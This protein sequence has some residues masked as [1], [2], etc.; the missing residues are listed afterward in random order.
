MKKLISALLVVFQIFGLLGVFAETDKS[1]VFLWEDFN[2]KKTGEVITDYLGSCSV[3]ADGR[4][5]Y[6][7]TTIEDATK[8]IELA[9]SFPEK[10][11]V[12]YDFYSDATLSDTVFFKIKDSLSYEYELYSVSDG[13][14]NYDKQYVKTYNK[15]KWNNI[16]LMF[17]SVRKEFSVMLNGEYVV[18]RYKLPNMR[19]YSVSAVKAL[20]KA[21]SGE[22]GTLRVDNIYAYSGDTVQKNLPKSIF[23]DEEVEKQ[24]EQDNT[25]N[26]S[27]WDYS[28]PQFWVRE[29]FEN[30]DDIYTLG[31]NIWPKGNPNWGIRTDD[32]GNKYLYMDRQIDDPFVDIVRNLE[33]EYVAGSYPDDEYLVLE[34]DFTINNLGRTILFD[35]KSRTAVSAMLVEMSN[36]GVLTDFN[37]VP[38]DSV[39]KGDKFKMQCF[40]NFKKGVYSVYKDGKEILKD[41][42]FTSENFG[43]FNRW[44]IYLYNGYSAALSVD[45]IA[46]YT[47]DKVV[48]VNDYGGYTTEYY[49]SDDFAVGQALGGYAFRDGTSYAIIDGERKSFSEKSYMDIHNQRFYV[50]VS[51]A[52]DCIKGEVEKSSI[53]TVDGGEYV[54][55]NVLAELLGLK[56]IFVDYTSLNYGLAVISASDLSGYETGKQQKRELNDYLQFE[57][58]KADRILNDFK[59]AAAGQHPRLFLNNKQLASWINQYKTE[60]TKKAEG[61]KIIQEAEDFVN[62]EP[63]KYTPAGIRIDTSAFLPRCYKLIIAYLMTNDSRYKTALF[64]NLQSWGDSGA[65]WAPDH[66]LSATDLVLVYSVSYDWLYDS[67]SE[68]EKE[69]LEN[70]IKTKSL[71][72]AYAAAY[73]TW[74]FNVHWLP[75]CGDDDRM[76]GNWDVICQAGQISGAIA[77]MD[78]YPEFCSKLVETGL[79]SIEYSITEFGPD[80]EWVEGPHYWWYTL[81][82]LTLLLNVL[83]SSL[84]TNYGY[85]D[86]RGIEKTINFICGSV[87][88]QGTFGYGDAGY[89]TESEDVPKVYFFPYFTK[90]FH[91]DVYKNYWGKLLEKGSYISNVPS[92]YM[93]YFVDPRESFEDKEITVDKDYYFRT[94]KTGSFRDGFSDDA[95]FLAYHCGSNLDGHM[96]YDSG[97]FVFDALGERW[98]CE[99]GRDT[100]DTDNAYRARA[101]GNNVYVINP[102]SEKGQDINTPTQTVTRHESNDYEALAVMDISESYA[103]WATK[104]IRGFKLT[105]N[106]KALVIRDEITLK[107][108]SEFYWFMNCY[109]AVDVKIDGNTAILR[110]NGKQMKFE[111]ISNQPLELKLMDAERLPTS[112]DKHPN[113]WDN[114]YYKK[115]AL[116][117]KDLKGDLNITV[118]I[119]P[120]VS[121][122]TFSKPEDIPVSEWKLSDKAVA[123]VKT[124][125]IIDNVYING[126]AVGGFD[127]NGSLITYCVQ[128]INNVNITADYNKEL[129]D[130][131]EKRNDDGSYTLTVWDKN[132]P[133][134]YKVYGV[135]LLEIKS[136]DA[137]RKILTP[138]KISASAEPQAANAARNVLDGSAETRW[139]ATGQPYIQYDFEKEYNISQIGIQVYNGAQRNIEFDVQVST[140]GENYRTVYSGATSGKQLETEFFDIDSVNAKHIRLLCKKSTQGGKQIEWISVTEFYAFG[141]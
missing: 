48:D 17:N 137:S 109:R 55:I 85:A 18:Y 51:M 118:K 58:P 89:G 98:A 13:G 71:N 70:I 81:D 35:V 94:T 123:E 59:N 88:P 38:F 4:N 28:K 97:C 20:F 14:K 132:N 63:L 34:A 96:Q 2:S 140:D 49:Q 8:Q 52:K 82:H 76:V 127:K 39:K 3:K 75:Y 61:D 60:P 69:Y 27:A 68:Y 7:E 26:Q 138:L 122:V 119:S 100:Y 99:L 91:N 37:G 19:V 93:E 57:R 134:N 66:F 80:G 101:E 115:L 56:N 50:P 40:I 90:I 15:G 105:E 136:N 22:S 86:Y 87:G 53:E 92:L 21:K 113:E 29:G 25:D 111:F 103:S 131:A 84:H 104:A 12:E 106:R 9:S 42:G 102:G 43:R 6:I 30:H 117:G 108:N 139:S 23:N 124:A 33:K 46:V 44:R 64:N 54:E 130:M 126:N 83:D 133:F 74:R 77:L 110:R 5:K 107:D 141:N 112:G 36:D 45:N 32:T 120:D 16:K 1:D 135:S 79:R 31:F 128:D 41:A 78:K 47:Y 65:E 62:A 67:W 11:T 116:Y 72:Y 114:S 73:G 95:T 129:F 121:A 24:E 125:P 10:F